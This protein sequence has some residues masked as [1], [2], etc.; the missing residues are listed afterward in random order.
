MDYSTDKSSLNWLLVVPRLTGLNDQ[1][2][3]F[4]VGIA[5]V[6]SA[7]KA[8]GRNVFTLNMNYKGENPKELLERSIKQNNIDVVASGGLSPQFALLYE[9]F[10]IAKQIDPRITTIAGGGII[11]SAPVLAM[12]ALE[13]VDYG[14]IGEGEITICELASALETNSEP[15]SV[16]GLVY[17]MNGGFATTPPREEISDLD[18][19]PWPDYDELEYAETLSKTPID[20]L[21]ANYAN[22]RL[23]IAV[24]SRSC[25]YNCTF[26]F[27][28]S[29]R[30][31]R[32]RSLDSFFDELDWMIKKYALTSIYLTDECF[33][34]SL[35]FAR[36]FCE[37][38]KLF[39]IRWQCSSRVDNITKE[40][41]EVLR[42]A[43]CD[44]INF[45]VESA[46][47]HILKSMRKNITREQI[48][49]AFTLCQQVGIAAKGGLIFG[50][51]EETVETAMD[52]I[53]WLKEHQDWAIT[54]HWIIAY[55]GSHVYNVACERGVIHNPVQHLKDGCP[56]VNFSKMTDD[57]RKEINSVISMFVNEEHEI[58]TNASIRQGQSGK[59]TVTGDCPYC[60][61]KGTFLNI[62]P[63]KPIKSEVCQE[64][65]NTLHL[66]GSDY[67]D[68]AVFSD[69]VEAFLSSH[70]IA[71]WPVVAGIVKLFE[72]SPVLLDKNVYFIDSSR[73][74]QGM[75]LC[76]KTVFP[77]E[78]I[79]T[80]GIETIILTTTTYISSAIIDNIKANYHNV[81]RIETI[82][83]LF[84]PSEQ[85]DATE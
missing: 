67:V 43:G 59:I 27:H 58:L 54:M 49:A 50:D 18:L 71:F 85:G 6:S 79:K 41:L 83:K 5:Y 48:E 29:G 1:Q 26:C 52:S 77:P 10:N 69:S 31:Y 74:K 33:L 53:N 9:I 46:N 19:L 32:T 12:T 45:G 61:K 34:K 78:I 30:K 44:R 11:T 7:L 23:G 20:V 55:P 66:Y 42:D 56:E 76:G 40:M 38:I 3:L 21:T 57:E 4:P 2:Y 15:R 16:N 28:S 8:S 80:H 22:E 70:K 84:F 75:D 64:C 62:D 81:K 60:G 72:F 35:D 63:F 73:Y 37:R 51:L 82:G 65:R 47:D 68:P 25:P 13:N 14:V 24:Y 39:N 17:R 36:E